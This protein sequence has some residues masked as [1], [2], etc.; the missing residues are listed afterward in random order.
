[1]R[2]TAN[3]GSRS[4]ADASTGEWAPRLRWKPNAGGNQNNGKQQPGSSSRQRSTGTERSG[5]QGA[6]WSERNASAGPSS[7][8][9]SSK[10]RRRNRSKDAKVVL[11]PAVGRAADM[12]ANEGKD[13]KWQSPQGSTSGRNEISF[14]STTACDSAECDGSSLEMAEKPR[15]VLEP[16]AD[17]GGPRLSLPLERSPQGSKR[18]K[19]KA[20]GGGVSSSGEPALPRG[21]SNSWSKKHKGTAEPPR[22]QWRSQARSGWKNSGNGRGYGKGW[23]DK[24]EGSGDLQTKTTAEWSGAAGWSSTGWND[25]SS[26][27]YLGPKWGEESSTVRT[28]FY[29]HDKPPPGVSK[30]AKFFHDPPGTYAVMDTSEGK[31]SKAWHSYGDKGRIFAS[32][33]DVVV[34]HA[35]CNDG[36]GAAYAVYQGLLNERYRR[37]RRSASR[38]QASEKS[39]YDTED[40]KTPTPVREDQLPKFFGEVHSQTEIEF[41]YEGKNV[42]LLDFVYTDRA[43]LEELGRKCKR[44]IILDHHQST[45]TQWMTAPVPGVEYII[46]QRQSACTLAWDYFLGRRAR[47]PLLLRYIEDCDIARFTYYNSSYFQTGF[48]CKR[49]DYEPPIFTPGKIDEQCLRAFADCVDRGD[50]FLNECIEAG[51]SGEVDEYYYDVRQH[52]WRSRLRRLKLFPKLLAR[53]VNCSSQSLKGRVMGEMLEYRGRGAKRDDGMDVPE[54]EMEPK[55]D[56]AL[57]YFFD[58]TTRRYRVSMSTDREDVDVAEICTAYGG[59]GHQYVGGFY[60]TCYEPGSKKTPPPGNPS[61]GYTVE[62]IFEP[63]DFDMDEEDSSEEAEASPCV[64]E[65]WNLEATGRAA[66]SLHMALRA[67]DDTLIDGDT[68][69]VL[70]C[71]VS[72]WARPVAEDG[73]S[74]WMLRPVEFELLSL[75]LRCWDARILQKRY[76]AFEPV[77]DSTR[78]EI[79]KLMQL[80]SASSGSSPPPPL[81]EPPRIKRLDSF[82]EC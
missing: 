61:C 65:E 82:S 69:Q 72:E 28:I 57:I 36:M 43:V 45:A 76:P 32:E 2:S 58:D 51:S 68:V 70:D 62:E 27:I 78:R 60:F 21:G 22:D 34:F 33:V 13:G 19:G 11:T 25:D 5:G 63:L 14:E 18:R 81:R 67:G 26:E 35:S 17:H 49:V 41:D 48:R 66:M 71:Y 1:M 44:C 55:A 10:G 73:R 50:E 77:V 24:R 39:W 9:R 23:E 37:H 30:N 59:G 56:L 52:V 64:A 20:S 46:N 15:V 38:E 74:P 75:A 7:R 12:R 29:D 8:R 40:R 54:E 79:E 53:V 6:S 47:V 4:G 80:A 16:R 31:I 42:V 3:S